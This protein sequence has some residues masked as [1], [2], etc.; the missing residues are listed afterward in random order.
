MLSTQE[1]KVMKDR[2]G[3]SDML[4]EL[5]D[6][7]IGHMDRLAVISFKTALDEMIDFHRFLIDA[8]ATTTEIGK[9]T[10]FAQIQI[11]AWPV[12]PHRE[13]IGQYRRLFERAIECITRENAFVYIL[14]G[15]PRR[16]LPVNGRDAAPEVTASLLD[17]SRTFVDQLE[18]WLTRRRIFESI[19]GDEQPATSR[20]AGSD[21]QAYEEVVRRFAGEWETTLR[22]TKSIY[23]WG[24]KGI[25]ADEEW[26]R[27]R[28]SWPLLERHL[29]NTAY[30]LAAAVWN[31][32]EIGADHYCEVLLRWFDAF[33][34]Q[35][36]HDFRLFEGLL[37]PDLL[38]KKWQDAQD[39]VRHPEW[40]QPTPA[41]VFS[42]IIQGML[43]DAIFVV[44]GIMLAWFI[45]ARQNSDI[46][47]RIVR[48]LLTDSVQD[49]AHHVKRKTGFQPLM[50]SFLRMYAFAADRYG[51]Q[52]DNFFDFL[53]NRLETPKVTLRVY[54]WWALD[55]CEALLIPWLSCLLAFMPPEGD[56]NA[57]RAITR[58]TAHED[59]FPK[60]DTSLRGLLDALKRAMAVL[61]SD[62]REDLERGTLALQPDA[63]LDE[64]IARLASIFDQ[65][66][67]AIKVQRRK[68]LQSRPVD[69]AKLDAVRHQ[70]EQAITT[71]NGGIDVFQ[72]F[73]IVRDAT[74]L[75]EYEVRRSQVE[76][77]WFT[78]PSMAQEP[79]WD[80]EIREVQRFAAQLVLRD[81]LR[82]PRRVIDTQDEASFLAALRYEARKIRGAGRQPVLL[83]R[84]WYDPPWIQE[85]FSWSEGRPPGIE[86]KMKDDVRADHYIGTIDGV[87]VYNGCELPQ[88]NQSFL[89]PADIL[90]TVKYGIDSQ[91]RIVDLKFCEGQEGESG[92]LAVHLLQEAQWQD[93]EVVVIQYP[94]NNTE[95]EEQ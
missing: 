54:N 33:R 20:L 61:T 6:K 76:K 62:H 78:E 51:H 63:P 37:T 56:A 3:P 34:H 4:E 92:S 74:T 19:Q 86:I 26:H 40:H 88:E 60:G 22:G 18:A 85:W 47:P 55:R 7:V 84:D 89:F 11:G 42:T 59:A 82:R 67:T 8:Y 94:A 23:E 65:I 80:A 46:V 83:V 10:S 30:M 5:A 81:F 2:S 49:G 41:G 39:M 44:S 29:R 75:H 71:G 36:K 25:K 28:E 79:M 12:P 66:V 58:L 64:R 87:D 70:F 14:I 38:E 53:N 90:K 52:L 15:V 93:D 95:D 35:L 16:L 50:T 69:Q 1:S 68:R 24:A 43:D 91:N 57:V 48:R 72:G 13:W 45:E 27:Y 32:D 73:S 21:K 31:E 9:A 77:G 17:L